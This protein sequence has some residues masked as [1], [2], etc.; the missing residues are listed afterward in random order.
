MRTWMVGLLGFVGCG[1]AVEDRDGDGFAAP[2]DCDDRDAARNPLAPEVCDGVD[3]DCDGAVDDDA[4]D[5]ETFVYA[6]RDGDGVGD[7]DAFEVACG[8]SAGFVLVAGDC[9]D[10]DDTTFPGAD[11]RCDDVDH[12]CDGSVDDGAIDATRYFADA[13]GDGYGDGPGVTACEPPDGHVKTAGD[14]DDD[15]DTIA[16]GA[17]ERCNGIDDDC[18]TTIDED[19]IDRVAHYADLDGDGYGADGS[20]E[21]ACTVPSGRTGVGGDCAD[22]DPGR[23]PGAGERCDGVDNDCDSIVD[24]FTVPT[25]H[26]T[27]AGAVAAAPDGSEICVEPGTYGGPV[28]VAGRAVGIVGL[29]GP[30]VTS[31]ELADDTLIVGDSATELQLRG[32]TVTGA[33]AGTDPFGRFIELEDTGSSASNGRLELED[34]HF[35]DIEADFDTGARGG[36]VS[37]AHVD[38]RLRD[39]RFTNVEL[40]A[41]NPKGVVVQGGAFYVWWGSLELDGVDVVQSSI[42]ID[43]ASRCE[44]RGGWFLQIG[45]P[46]S[47]ISTVAID[48]LSFDG[49]TIPMSCGT[50]ADIDGA[51]LDLTS[52]TGTGSAWSVRGVELTATASEVD[53]GSLVTL[54]RD[55]ALDGFALQDNVVTLVGARDGESRGLIVTPDELAIDHLTLAGNRLRVA[56]TGGSVTR[57]GLISAPFGSDVAL[58]WVDVRGNTIAAD[59][60]VTGGLVYHNGSLSITNGII[61]GNAIG[62]AGTTSLLG[63]IF[64][65]DLDTAYSLDLENVDIVANP[66]AAGSAGG[67]VLWVDDFVDA[68][69]V[70][71]VSSSLV[72]DFIDGSNPAFTVQLPG[73]ACTWDY[74]NVFATDGVSPTVGC[75]GTMSVLAVAP[76]YRDVSSPDPRGWDLTLAPGS[77]LVDAG[78]PMVMDADG[79]PTDI[80]AFGGPGG[81]GW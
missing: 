12:D 79:S 35:A 15:D 61:A 64:F 7:E 52:L 31:I 68:A 66:I 3:N 24:S 33:S 17:D 27:I 48:D 73:A 53:G 77:R 30:D 81:G 60:G 75:A 34:V 44:L 6:D 4:V 29:G 40:G 78:D 49:V 11:E 51:L 36:L 9:D 69:N 28:D 16:P 43:S 22:D 65:S 20:E 58:R 8:P 42:P 47:P 37:T 71:V 46:V 62:T 39:V 2:E 19:A 54:G 5:A 32:F 57:G 1:A 13:D 38:V 10:L 67:A 41:A 18:D 45:R 14:C 76:D 72:G 59:D 55:F 23:S 63:G 50:A 80:G 74:N 56:S 21:R 70:R 25:H 26:A